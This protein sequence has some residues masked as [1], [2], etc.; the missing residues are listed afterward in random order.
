MVGGVGWGRFV[1]GVVFVGAC[2]FS[3]CV[4]VLAL[5][6]VVESVSERV[7]GLRVRGVGGD[8]YG[9]MVDVFLEG[10]LVLRMRAHVTGDHN[11]RWAA[12]SVEVV[13]EVKEWEE[14]SG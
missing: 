6:V 5:E 4:G 13:D 9:T 7:E 8:M 2:L 3:P 10:G 14:R 11:E 12:I 1:G